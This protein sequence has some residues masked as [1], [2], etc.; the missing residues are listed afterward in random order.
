M[1]ASVATA[2]ARR[3]RSITS[4]PSPKAALPRWTTASPPAAAATPARALVSTGNH[5]SGPA[6]TGSENWMTRAPLERPRVWPTPLGGVDVPK[7]KP[8]RAACSC[9]EPIVPPRRRYC[10]DRC[11]ERE[12]GVEATCRWCAAPFW[13]HYKGAKWY[14]STTCAGTARYYDGAA[15]LVPWAVCLSCRTWFLARHGRRTCGSGTCRYRL[16]T[17]TTVAVTCRRCGETYEAKR[18]RGPY[19]CT[20]CVAAAHA[21]ARRSGK[22]RR[23]ARKRGLPSDSY[24]PAEIFERDRWTCQICH[25]RVARTK[26]VPHPRAPTIDH[27]VPLADPLTP[28]DVRIN[29]QCAHFL[30]NSR[31]SAGAANDQLRL[32]G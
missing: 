1:E 10:S 7:R 6:N 3:P 31:K 24:R 21:D 5:P 18:T 15:T 22:R 26:V 12:R 11:G 20:D 23:R 30:C 29:V 8:P 13:S 9:G 28:G 32:L 17:S 27:I 16:T 19:T 14:C 25:R 2:A 4:S